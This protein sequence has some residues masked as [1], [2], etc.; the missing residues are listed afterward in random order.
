MGNWSPKQGF[1]LPIIVPTLRVGMR[2]RTLQR[3]RF[4]LFLLMAWA[5]TMKTLERQRLH[6]NAECIGIYT[7]LITLYK[8]MS[9]KILQKQVF[10]LKSNTCEFCVGTNAQS[11]GTMKKAATQSTLL[12]P[13]ENISLVFC[14]VHLHI[15]NE[16]RCLDYLTHSFCHYYLHQQKE[17]SKCDLHLLAHLGQG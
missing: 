14:H 4:S 13:A 17:L 12:K 7:I 11:V 3:P 9:Y 1:G 2:L 16:A 15:W 10:L 8:T 5:L 6:S